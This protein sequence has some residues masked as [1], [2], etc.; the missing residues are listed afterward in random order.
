MKCVL[1]KNKHNYRSQKSKD[2]CTQSLSEIV[3]SDVC[4]PMRHA[5][6][7]QKRYFVTF[8]DD[9][10]NY[11]E[12]YFIK[13]KSE[14]L[15]VFEQYKNEVETFTGEKIKSLQTDNSTEYCNLEF[16]AFLQKHGIKRR[17]TTPHTPQQNGV[18]E[19]KNR[20]LVEMARCMMKQAG[21]PPHFWAEAIYNANYTRNR[22]PTSA[23]SGSIPYTVWTGKTPTLA[24]MQVFGAKTFV[25]DKKQNKGKFESRSKPG[26]FLGYS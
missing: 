4:G 20:T 13:R 8:I 14:V 24:H 11:C 19:R 3:Y 7:A 23:L 10:S 6:V 15:I 21:V 22:C 2:K 25:L 17:L 26:I 1:V 18:A 5:S 9:K 16:D 12:V